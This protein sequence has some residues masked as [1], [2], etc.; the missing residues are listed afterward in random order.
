MLIFSA[1]HFAGLLGGI[2]LPD[3]PLTVPRSYLLVKNGFWMVISII[4]SF[5]LFT[6]RRWAVQFTRGSALVFGLWYW[7]D[8][9]F[10]MHSDFTRE[11]WPIAAFT[12]GALLVV[13]FGLTSR[14]SVR[15]Y[16]RESEE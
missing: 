1:V 2:K 5:A 11:S 12:T 13:L 10:I 7:V 9:T 6:G 14:V 16:F 15:D 3:L 8:R 4:A